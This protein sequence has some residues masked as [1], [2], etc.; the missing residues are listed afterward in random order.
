MGLASVQSGAE[1]SIEV[2]YEP[3]LAFV[4]AK[5]FDD[6]GVAPVLVVALPMVN[7]VNSTYR[8]KFTPTAGK[9]YVVNKA[10]YTSGAFTVV[11]DDYGQGSDA[12]QCV[13]PPE[14]SELSMAFLN[15]LIDHVQG[16]VD[17]S[18]D[19]IGVVEEC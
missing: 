17:D 10:V 2:T 4:A 16:V 6:S 13:A 1:V 5:I 18:T 15:S 12:F 9:T 11:N 7:V 14:S 19:I 8:A 3:G